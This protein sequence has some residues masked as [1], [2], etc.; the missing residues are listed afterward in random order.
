MTAKDLFCH[1]LNNNIKLNKMYI[2]L[3]G[4]KLNFEL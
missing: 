3:N 4:S 1:G 2:I